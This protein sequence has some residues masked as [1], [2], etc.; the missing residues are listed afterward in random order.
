MTVFLIVFAFVLFF[1]FLLIGS[2]DKT[3]IKTDNETSKT[4]EISEE[5]YQTTQTVKN[6]DYDIFDTDSNVIDY[7]NLEHYLPVIFLQNDR[8]KLIFLLSE[9]LLSSIND[10]TI[11]AFRSL[12]ITDTVLYKD[13]IDFSK[14]FLAYIKSFPESVWEQS[15]FAV[16][17][18]LTMNI[19]GNY[20]SAF[21]GKNV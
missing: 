11:M 18:I 13:L 7:A 20:L 6:F 17:H 4:C 3:D 21:C 8:Q 14:Y 19:L 10:K 5:P 9:V 1:Y 15:Q 12:V 2:T 16:P